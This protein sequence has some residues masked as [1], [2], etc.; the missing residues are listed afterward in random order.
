[1]QQFNGEFGKKI[2]KI[3][4]D[5]WAVL[6]LHDWPGNIRELKNYLRYLCFSANN[7]QLELYNLQ[8]WDHQMRSPFKSKFPSP[9]QLHSS[10]LFNL[11]V[12]SLAKD[13]M[14]PISL[15]IF[16]RIKTVAG[17]DIV[18]EDL[19]NDIYELEKSHGLNS[20]TV[21]FERENYTKWYHRM[22]NIR[23][24]VI[25]SPKPKKYDAQV[26]P[27]SLEAD[28]YKMPLKEAMA[29]IETKI[30]T[31]HLRL[32]KDSQTKAA[33]SLGISPSLL[34]EKMKRFKISTSKSKRKKSRK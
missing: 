32:S 7:E 31:H 30:I 4:S 27:Y 29:N 23:K 28:Y 18:I 22:E 8:E 11:A 20:K 21:Q 2:D 25:L 10:S 13:K 16:E 14:L 17:K 1:V 15:D 19:P 5:L 3:A 26:G 6:M 12:F 33:K 24:N 34:N 9:I